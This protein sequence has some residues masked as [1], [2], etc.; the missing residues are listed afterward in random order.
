MKIDLHT[1]SY[2]SDGE[3]A[4]EGIV[5]EAKKNFISVL[6]ITDHN[7]IQYNL[8]TAGLAKESNIYFVEGI[9]ISTLYESFNKA[10]SLH[11]LG[12]GKKLDRDVIQRNLAETINGYN[13]RAKKIID[14]LN[15]E[16]PGIN[17]E[18][19]KLK[20]SNREAYVSRN[21]L[22]RLLVEYVKNISIKEALKQHVFVEEDDSWMMRTKDSFGL[23]SQ[24]GGVPI[25]AHS[26]R[27]LR[28]MGEENYDSM[29]DQFVR[30][31]LRGLEVYYPKHSDEEMT[32]IRG[33]ANK[34][35]LYVTAGSDWHG[36]TYTP[37]VT[38]GIN[39]NEKDLAPFLKDIVG[40]S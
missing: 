10:T 20:E 8:D 38:V 33:I 32:T 26:G 14:K 40:I 23:I 5:T 11:V 28:K 25:L 7:N 31:G 29:I 18:F 19:D 22:A 9:E 4:P 39:Y 34:H 15:R 12:Y 17:L 37:D 1:H 27:E 21:T 2:F 13:N 6:S 3:L 36:N 35:D 30:D 16:F 24:S